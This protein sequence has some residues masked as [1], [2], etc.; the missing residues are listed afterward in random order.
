MDKI[1]KTDMNKR[2]SN[3]L[4]DRPFLIPYIAVITTL[5]FVAIIVKG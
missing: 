2:V 1:S 4:Q 5:E 3:W